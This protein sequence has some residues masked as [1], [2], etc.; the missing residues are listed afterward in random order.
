MIMTFLEFQT[1][2]ETTVLSEDL[3]IDG[4]TTPF[5]RDVNRHQCGVLV[6]TSK[7]VPVRRRIDI[8][9]SQAEILCVELQ[10]G[11]NKVLICNCYRA[12]HHDV[13]D[14]CEAINNIIINYSNEFIDIIFLGDMNGRNRFSGQMTSQILRA[15]PCIHFSKLMILAI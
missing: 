15:E 7:N 14:F 6:Y 11:Q 13:I 5:R 3:E 2:L 1:W 4:F 10:I 9:P 8:E 12:P